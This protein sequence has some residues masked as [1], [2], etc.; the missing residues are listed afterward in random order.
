MEMMGRPVSMLSLRH[1]RAAGGPIKTS[2][3]LRRGVWLGMEI[4][5]RNRSACQSEH[6]GGMWAVGGH[7]EDAQACM[8]G[9][10]G[11]L[12][13]SAGG[14]LVGEA[15]CAV[16]EGMQGPGTVSGVLAVNAQW[17]RGPHGDCWLQRP[18]PPE[19]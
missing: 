1:P 7:G 9:S 17:G 11:S 6:R 4:L 13:G 8:L 12:T 16:G 10:P 18:N 2:L 3:S 14:S 19:Q 5:R 15:G